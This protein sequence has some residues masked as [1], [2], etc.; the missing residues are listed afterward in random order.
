MQDKLTRQLI[1]T[2]ESINQFLDG[3]DTISSGHN[4]FELHNFVL[5][6]LEELSRQRSNQWFI[7]KRNELPPITEENIDDYIYDKLNRRYPRGPSEKLMALRREN[8][9]ILWVLKNP[10]MEDLIESARENE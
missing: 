4:F 6:G 10:G 8:E 7:R 1:R 2:I 9:T 5:S 3:S